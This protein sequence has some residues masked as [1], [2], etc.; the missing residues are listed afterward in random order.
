M[1]RPRKNE[2]VLVPLGG[3]G[4]IGM[5][6]YAYGLGPARARRWLLVD[7]GVSFGGALEPGIDVILPDIRY[8]EEDGGTIEGILLTHGHEDHFG[9]VADL[10]PRL[11]APVYATPF[12]AALL[13]AKLIDDG[14]EGAV[15]ITEIPLGAR[16]AIG[17]FEIELV[18][19]THSIPE[20][21][22]VAIRSEGGLVL[23]SGDWKLDPDPVVGPPPNRARLKALG[24]EGVDV[25]ICDSTNAF[26]DGVSPSEAEVGASLARIIAESPHRVAVTT[27]ASNVARLRSVIEGAYAAD[28]QVVVVG[29][30]MRR[31]IDVARE[32][33][34]LP[35][36]Y[37][38]LSD[39]EY[40]YL[41]RDKVV[42][43]CTGSQGEPRGALA[44]I[45]EDEHPK[46]A[47]AAGDRAIFSSRTI[48]G[49]EKAVDRV[50]NALA[51]LGVEVITD[52]NALVHVSGHP[53]RGEL[54]QIYAWT[55]P[56]A[57]VPVHGE[58]R[59]LLEH[60]RFARANGVPRA[61]LAYN[62]DMVR[63]LP[64]PA[65][66]VDEVPFGRLYKDGRILIDADDGT[67]A[68]RRKLSYVGTAA[69]SLVIG[70]QGNLVAEPQ[71]VLI[72]IPLADTAGAALHEVALQAVAGAIEG[73]PRP[74]RKDA[75]S[76]AEAVRRAVRS[77]IGQSWGK[78]PVCSVM[79]SVI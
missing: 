68:A 70:R 54:E 48:P 25:L 3:V 77:A 1:T 29:R 31:V 67:V 2:L 75:A 76:V 34:Y 56:A 21:N 20:P 53:R 49:N 36:A 18:T 27:F 19:M 11:R 43:L 72:G 10:W 73:I 52:A 64:G 37:R 24:A 42:A 4:E 59:H 15:P 6:L 71:V 79:V 63:L 39:D 33:G 44:R 45:A 35:E 46:V 5:N 23:H 60:A 13:R 30:A 28:R 38:T 62:G 66:V 41:P 65:E 69:V 55:R 40:G 32:T 78:R 50:Q 51:R 7:L 47:F 17:P 16:L 74:R 8:L 61:V 9:A 58:P 57:L 22:A 26:R 14:Q 12:T